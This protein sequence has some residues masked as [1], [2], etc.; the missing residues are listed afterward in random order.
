M[1]PAGRLSV[2]RIRLALLAALL[3]LFTLALPA[4]GQSTGPTPT[5]SPTPGPTPTAL[6]SADDLLKRMYEA[7]V[8]RGSAHYVEVDRY[9]TPGRMRETDTTRGDVSWRDKLLR[10]HVTERT[11]DLTKKPH[12]TKVINTQL[13]IV[14]GTAALRDGHEKWRCLGVP[15]ADPGAASPGSADISSALL[16]NITTTDTDLGLTTLKGVSVWHIRETMVIPGVTPANHPGTGDYYI[17]QDDYRPLRETVDLTMTFTLPGKGNT[18][19]R[20]TI[21]ETGVEDFTRYGETFSVTLPK[22]CR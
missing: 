15:G 8:S 14:G 4:H 11:T 9:S 19:N 5:A 6:P 3:A 21:A 16:G 12:T 10:Q 13:Y 2:S 17:A 1:A 22:A 18:V 20:N 7:E